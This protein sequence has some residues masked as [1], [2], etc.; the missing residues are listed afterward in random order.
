MKFELELKIKTYLDINRKQK[1]KLLNKLLSKVFLLVF[2]CVS[3][4]REKKTEPKKNCRAFSSYR[5]H[6]HIELIPAC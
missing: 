6:P 4:A 1:S 5:F 2:P 3:E